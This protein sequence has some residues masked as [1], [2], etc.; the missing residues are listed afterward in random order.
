MAGTLKFIEKVCVQTAVYWGNPQP[1]GYGGNTFQTGIEIPVRWEDKTEKKI[2]KYGEETVCKAVVMTPEDKED[3]GYLYLGTLASLSAAQKADP[4]LVETA[5]P[6][7]T[8]ERTPLF[9]SSSKFVYQIY[10]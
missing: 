7:Q 8:I 9:K 5:Y 1:D 6:I 2:N 10:L 4:K 3:G